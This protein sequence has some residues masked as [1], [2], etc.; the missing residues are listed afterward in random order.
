MHANSNKETRFTTMLK[1][2]T[3]SFNDGSQREDS[4]TFDTNNAWT[5][6][7]T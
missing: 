4:K 2:Y 7:V 3:T 1:R 5:T 6:S